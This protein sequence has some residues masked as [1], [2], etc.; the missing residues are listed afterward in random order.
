MLGIV[1]FH[2]FCCKAPKPPVVVAKAVFVGV[3]S[4]GDAYT[5]RFSIEVLN[6]KLRPDS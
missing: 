2:S 5:K 1:P 4:F 6:V 3:A